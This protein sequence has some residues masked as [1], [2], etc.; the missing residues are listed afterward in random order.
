MHSLTLW[1]I[2]A[3]ALIILTGGLFATLAALDWL[4]ARNARRRHPA[5]LT[6]VY[7]H[8]TAIRRHEHAARPYDYDVDGL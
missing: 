5:R 7:A 6:N 3:A 2:R 4:E 8:P 1:L